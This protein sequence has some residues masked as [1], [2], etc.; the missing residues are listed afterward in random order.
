MVGRSTFTWSGQVS[1]WGYERGLYA[2]C[3]DESPGGF[4]ALT[5]VKHRVEG[6]LASGKQGWYVYSNYP[7]EACRS[8]TAQLSFVN[9][10]TLGLLGDSDY[11]S[12][13][14][15]QTNPS[16]PDIDLPVFIAELK[17]LPETFARNGGKLLR[18]IAKYNLQYQ[19]AI[20]PL[21][22]DLLKLITCVDMIDR[23]FEELEKLSKT[24]LR[25]KRR[26]DSGSFTQNGTMALN[27]Q[28]GLSMTNR[29]TTVAY[30]AKVWG[31]VNWFPSAS[32]P[33]DSTNMRSVAR[34][35]VL[36]L[37]IDGATAWELIPFS[38]LADWYTGLGDFLMASRNIVPCFHDTPFIMEHQVKEFVAL[39]NPPPGVSCSDF[40]T[41]S[42]RKTR[43]R[44]SPAPITATL[45]ALTGK[46]LSILS[47]L[48]AGKNRY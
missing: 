3:T 48:V 22:S 1:N 13:L 10:S 8:G 14:V 36:G 4:S 7:L 33:R 24:G 5:V 32:F 38:W 23:R 9:R 35:A 26:L 37:T 30:A 47:S 18:K 41:F 17:D 45:P 11:A 31:S 29:P 28:V 21:V 15:A 6:G 20:K 25:R 40:H 16:R 12:K 19:F 43:S 34:R 44:S 2:Q 42:E 39:A 46:Q 27:S